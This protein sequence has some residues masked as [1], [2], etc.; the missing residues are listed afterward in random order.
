M[1]TR[2]VSVVGAR[3]VF[4]QEIEDDMDV[5]KTLRLLLSE[6]MAKNHVVLLFCVGRDT[7]PQVAIIDR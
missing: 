3:T 7:R 1:D 2:E 5:E 4:T 6:M